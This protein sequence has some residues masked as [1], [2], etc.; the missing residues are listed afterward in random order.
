[1]RRRRQHT[2]SSKLWLDRSGFVCFPLAFSE[3]KHPPFWRALKGFVKTFQ[4]PLASCLN[5]FQGL[6]KAFKSLIKT[7]HWRPSNGL[8]RSFES[9]FSTESEFI[10]QDHTQCRKGKKRI[11]VNKFVLTVYLMLHEDVFSLSTGQYMNGIAQYWKRTP[12]GVVNGGNL[13]LRRWLQYVSISVCV[14]DHVI[15]TRMTN[16]NYYDYDCN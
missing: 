7:R 6:S 16:H 9:S 3:Q 10:P 15:C 12:S 1:M 8:R 5:V 11:F 13:I 2:N 14:C 4:R